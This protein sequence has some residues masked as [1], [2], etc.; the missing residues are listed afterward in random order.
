MISGKLLVNQVLNYN[1]LPKRLIIAK[2]MLKGALH[3]IIKTLYQYNLKKE[4]NYLNRYYTKIDNSKTINNLLSIE[5]NF[6]NYYY[7]CFNKIIKGKI[8]TYTKRVR[9]P[10]DNYINTLL[11]FGNSLLY[12]TSL[13]EILKT[14]INPLIS[15]V[16]EPFER[17]YSLNLDIADI[18]KPLI[19]D[20]I[21]F[22][23]I[24]R[25]QINENDFDK[26]LNFCY[27]KKSGRLKF[28]KE[29]DD[30]LNQTIK[31]YGLKRSVSYRYLLRLECY[32]LIKYFLEN[33]KY[34]S[35]KINW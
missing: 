5:G 22:K 18:F 7:S 16:H 29:Y 35:F 19:V 1:T 6:R 23:L 33:K 9:N 20:R 32:K 11:S 26:E 30:K 12:N 8:F 3:N 27:L 2:E 25:G 28:I 31:H 15:F 34:K 4:I 21:I 17:R 13:C 10:P 24:N 14:Q